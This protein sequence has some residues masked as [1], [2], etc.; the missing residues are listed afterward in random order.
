MEP[1]PTPEP[2]PEPEEPRPVAV[3][4]I[5]EQR[6][7]LADRTVVLGRPKEQDIQIIDPNVTRRHVDERR[8]RQE[9]H[10]LDLDS[11]NGIEVEGRRVRQLAL[12]DGARFTLG[13]TEVVFSRETR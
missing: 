2:P 7:E 9:L 4:T 6:H 12:E 11:T 8:Q 10:V 1:L 13:S 3:L 5:G